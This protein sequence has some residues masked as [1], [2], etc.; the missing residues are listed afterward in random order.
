[1]DTRGSVAAFTCN[2][3]NQFCHCH[4]LLLMNGV[5]T[6]AS[7]TAIKPYVIPSVLSLYLKLASAVVPTSVFAPV[8]INWPPH[9]A[10]MRASTAPREAW[11]GSTF[12]FVI[13]PSQC[14]WPHS[15]DSGLHQTMFEPT[16]EL[17]HCIK[18]SS[19]LW[20][21]KRYLFL[22]EPVS[23]SHSCLQLYANRVNSHIVKR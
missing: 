9:S 19:E 15:S 10:V 12:H 8:T 22:R 2:L 3:L 1:M 13:Y 14:S 7:M 17:S 16:L 21:I 20:K 23:C 4:F 11:L 5:C 18:K 6:S